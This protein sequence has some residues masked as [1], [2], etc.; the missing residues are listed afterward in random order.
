MPINPLKPHRYDTWF[1]NRGG[2]DKNGF[3]NQPVVTRTRWTVELSVV[4]EFKKPAD[5]VALSGGSNR[6]TGKLQSLCAS[7]GRAALDQS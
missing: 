2:S 5:F 1:K 7:V 3:R 6:N 4:F